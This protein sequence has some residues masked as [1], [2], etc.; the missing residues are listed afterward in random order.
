M[1]IIPR[2][3]L[4]IRA[5]KMGLYMQDRGSPASLVYSLHNRVRGMTIYVIM[6]TARP[7]YANSTYGADSSFLRL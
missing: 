6:E 5:V 1:C 2:R 3:T 7:D 4:L